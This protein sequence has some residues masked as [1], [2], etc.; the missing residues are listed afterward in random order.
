MLE[1]TGW[2]ILLALLS[3]PAGKLNLEKL[4]SLVSVRPI[5]LGSW[6]SWLEDRRLLAGVVDEVT[7]EVRA[8]LTTGGRLLLDRYLSATIELEARTHH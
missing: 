7:G 2:D 1:E 3:D 8:M 5:T 4:A 6:L